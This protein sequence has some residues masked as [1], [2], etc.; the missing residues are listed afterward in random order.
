MLA[1]P[2]TMNTELEAI[3][4]EAE[5]QTEVEPLTI[6][7]YQQALKDDRPFVILKYYAN[8]KDKDAVYI[9]A[10]EKLAT[11][12]PGATF[13]TFNRSN[14]SEALLSFLS[15]NTVLS[16]D[17]SHAQILVVS[18]IPNRDFN[19]TISWPNFTS[20]SDNLQNFQLIRSSFFNLDRFRG[21][22]VT[23][24]NPLQ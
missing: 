2:L 18:T 6:A 5:E 15:D 12:Y 4:S 9:E 8:D 11:D 3:N 20:A 21:L 1:I 16:T 17:D 10:F 14:A 22:D 7:S 24:I 19:E 23:Q 13:L